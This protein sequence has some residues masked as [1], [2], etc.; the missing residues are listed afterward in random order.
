MF[1]LR[2]KLTSP[3]KQGKVLYI[4]LDL[5]IDQNL[6]MNDQEVDLSLLVY[7]QEA[8][9]NPDILQMTQC[10]NFSSFLV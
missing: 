10:L 7:S 3:H 5:P 4:D 6:Y 2:R 9:Y 8:G 1:Y